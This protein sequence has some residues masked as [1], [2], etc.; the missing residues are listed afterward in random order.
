MNIIFFTQA[1]CLDLFFSLMHAMGELVPLQKKG[2][3]IADSNFYSKF[4]R[5]HPEIE[6]DSFV[7]LKEGDIIR[8]SKQIKV[9]MRFLEEYEK[10][11][12]KPYLWDAL[13]ADRRIYYGKRYAYDQD[14][15]SRFSHERM[16]S[17]LQAGLKRMEG[18]FDAVQPDIIVSFHCV[19][20]GDYLSSLF[21]QAR[22]IPVLNLR[23]TR[24]RNY[25]YAAESIM[26]PSDYLK[27]EY[28]E[29]LRNGI[30]NSLKKDAE[31]YIQ[32]VRK[33]HA[34]YEGV[35]L[36]SNKPPAVR[37]KQTVFPMVKKII[38]LLV[39]EYKY[40]FGEY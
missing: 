8:E 26:E 40:H 1:E 5:Q 37:K 39:R 16:L 35:V 3:Y 20:V 34:L 30:D 2:F 24:I 21:A 29:L 27:K 15:H 32:E 33:T 4:R 36:P 38:G 12:G 11:I 13:V 22:N 18:F 31:D 28:E 19:T 14:Y 9:D 10:K 23:P 25:F 17:I 6:S 7:L